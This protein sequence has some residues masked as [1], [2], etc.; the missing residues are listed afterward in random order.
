VVVYYLPV[1]AGG[2]GRRMTELSTGPSV[3]VSTSRARQVLDRT[4]AWHLVALVV[5]AA[6][7]P[8]P[9]AAWTFAA[10]LVGAILFTSV[11]KPLRVIVGVLSAA[12][13]LFVMTYGGS[14]DP[15]YTKPPMGSVNGAGSAALAA[16]E[17]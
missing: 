1:V 14:Q 12:V 13:V 2:V 16:A 3:G 10:P 8:P 6:A 5:I 15:H 4:P 7:F 9:F 17:A 11:N